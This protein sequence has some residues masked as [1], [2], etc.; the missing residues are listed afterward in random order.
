MDNLTD[1]FKERYFDMFSDIVY[2][3]ELNTYELLIEL[4][5]GREVIYDA[6]SDEFRSIDRDDYFRTILK[7]KLKQKHM[8]QKS[9]SIRTR[10]I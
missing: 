3:L 4:S 5:D 1:Y 8:T 9:L 6:F 7:K 2:S 10:Y